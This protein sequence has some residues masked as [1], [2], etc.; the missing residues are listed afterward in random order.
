[1]PWEASL[2]WRVCSLATPDTAAAA[3]AWP[4]LPAALGFGAVHCI[5]NH[6]PDRFKQSRR[7]SAGSEKWLDVQV[8]RGARPLFTVHAPCF[9]PQRPAG[10]RP[11][12]QQPPGSAAPAASLP[13]AALAPRSDLLPTNPLPVRLSPQVFDTTAECLGA[14][15]AAGFQIVVAQ[16]APDAV[17]IGEVDWTRPTAVVLGNEKDGAPRGRAGAAREYVVA[18]AAKGPYPGPRPWKRRRAQAVAGWLAG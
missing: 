5:N 17:P 11:S 6:E 2:G 15:K 12:P 14:A 9:W 10:R 1:M 4:P 8:R 13:G 18:A 7:S 3:A 16:L